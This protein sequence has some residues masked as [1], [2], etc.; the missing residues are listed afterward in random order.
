VALILRNLEVQAS[1]TDPGTGCPYLRILWTNNKSYILKVGI[2]PCS[3][4][5]LLARHVTD[6]WIA[7]DA[8]QYSY[9]RFNDHILLSDGSWK[10][11]D[12]LTLQRLNFLLNN[13]QIQFVPNKKH[14]M[15][16]L[17]SPTGSCCF[18]KQSLFIVR[19]R[20][21]TKVQSV[22]HRRH[23]MYLLQSPTG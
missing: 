9:S 19:T 3:S 10:P 8:H 21:N 20:R 23:I 4:E 16:P 7:A 13:I 5:R 14:I 17:Q 1:N 15:S 12:S 18:G 11:P 22:P 6:E 2:F